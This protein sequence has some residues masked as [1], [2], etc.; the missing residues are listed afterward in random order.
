MLWEVIQPWPTPDFTICEQEKMQQ[1]D[2][3]KSEILQ[4]SSEPIE[5]TVEDKNEPYRPEGIYIIRKPTDRGRVNY[6]T[7]EPHLLFHFSI[8]LFFAIQ[9]M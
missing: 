9:P 4:V 6:S 7:I 5:S 3:P 8:F 2:Q 1:F